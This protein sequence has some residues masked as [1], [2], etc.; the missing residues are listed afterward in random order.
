[1]DCKHFIGVDVSKDTLDI[2]M[3]TAGSVRYYVQI[4]NKLSSIRTN[5][6]RLFKAEGLTFSQVIFCMEHTGVYTLPLLNFLVAKKALIYMVSGLHIKKCLGIT[7]GKND[8]VDS[9]R[10]ALYAMSNPHKIRLYKAPRP[11]VKKLAALYAQRERLIKARK[12]ITTSLGEQNLFQ[13]KAISQSITRFSTPVT[14]II[15]KQIK[16]VEKAIHDLIG[17]DE[18]LSHLF[19]LVTSV[20]GIGEVTATYV[21]ITTNEFID[22]KDPKKYACYSGVVPF[23]HRSGSS[24]RRKIRVSH[25]ANKGIKTL[26]HMAARSAVKMKGELREYYE[27]KVKEGKHKMCV[28][29]AI[30]NKLILRIF[31]CVNGDRPFQKKYQ[32]LLG[33]P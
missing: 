1:M 33:N 10:I 2:S 18:N 20:D 14:L 31:S 8:Q 25:L 32:P 27:R 28:L 29:N 12:Q 16:A 13:E 23:E 4:P 11:E 30:R 24:I 6:A 3:A 7:R 17:S 22:F 5:L 19:E 26:L 15:T 9:E 21:L